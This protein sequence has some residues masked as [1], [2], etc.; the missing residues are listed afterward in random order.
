MEIKDHVHEFHDILSK[1][2][3]T[4]VAVAAIKVARANTQA[5]TW[6]YTHQPQALTSAI[7]SS[8][9]TT[10]ME[11]DH[12]LKDAAKALQKYEAHHAHRTHHTC[13]A[14]VTPPPTLQVQPYK[15]LLEGCVRALLALRHPHTSARE[16]VGGGQA[17]AHRGA[18][19]CAVCLERTT[20]LVIPHV[21]LH[22]V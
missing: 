12:E 3:D 9:A 10:M 19:Q 16:R 18:V 7:R 1:A 17:E 11:L 21:G 2:P 6:L 15:H 8:C 5:T 14:D 4:A 22:H 13:L 20:C